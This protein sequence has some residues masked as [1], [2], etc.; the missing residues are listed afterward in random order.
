MFESATDVAAKIIVA[1]DVPTLEDAVATV[2]QLP[3]VQFWKVGLQL[4]CASGPAI[5]D[6]LKGEEKRIFL[7]LKLHDIPNTMAAAVRAIVPFGVDF[8]TIHTATGSAGLRAAQ[9]A[10]GDSPTQLLGVTLLTSI[11][12]A[13]LRNELGWGYD[14][15]KYVRSMAYLAHQAGL[16]GVICSAQEAAQIKSEFGN[17]FLRVCPGIRPAGSET[18]DQ[19]RSFTPLS[20]FDQGASYL[21]VG[22]PILNAPDPAQA[23][24]NICQSCLVP[25]IWGE[26]P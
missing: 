2:R 23:F 10:L 18:Q 1:L 15:P 8:L 25:L 19:A 9:E 21:V 12:G 7:D 5:L 22:R 20:A 11:D 24:D 4:F 13:T 14:V 17:D 26:S 3:Q 6:V 16:G